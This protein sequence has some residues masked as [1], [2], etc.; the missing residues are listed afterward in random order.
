MKKII[1]KF[2]C[3]KN[4]ILA[5]TNLCRKSITY[6]C[7]YLATTIEKVNLATGQ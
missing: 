4:I 5:G 7:T 1:D 3:L 2:R 6:I